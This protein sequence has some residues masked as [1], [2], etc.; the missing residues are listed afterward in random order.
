MGPA[1]LVD[2]STFQSLS[3][4]EVFYLRQYYHVVYCST[5]F[6]ETLADLA[7]CSDIE[8]GKKEVSKISYKI[9]GMDTCFTTEFRE[10]LTAELF[11]YEI[12]MNGKPILSGGRDVVVD[13]GNR[14]VFF[15]E[16]PEY[17]ALRKWT[18]GEYSE[19]EKQLAENWRNST[20]NITLDKAK[21]QS[22]SFKKIKN[23][24]ELKKFTTEI[25][26]N[27]EFQL[28]L[29][30]L[31]LSGI[32]FRQDIRDK[33]CKRWLD[34]GMPL[35][36]NYAPY[37]YYYLLVNLTFHLGVSRNLVSDRLTNII[38]LEYVYY[39]P[40]CKVFTSSD[41]FLRNFSQLFLTEGQTFTWGEDLKSDLKAFCDYWGEKGDDERF[42]YQQDYENYPPDIPGSL[43]CSIWQKWARTGRRKQEKLTLERKKEIM[44]KLKPI[45]E[46]IKKIEKE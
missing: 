22:D 12:E 11:G 19:A 36:K 44:K 26:E 20:K 30:Q 28:D 18:G 42:R 7:K 37:T 32:T 16:P 1:I 9:N 21:N 27:P 35:I 39:L 31:V 4:G 14:G 2:K 40:F 8:A 43:T 29:L 46:Q 25:L 15:D 34:F 13:E 17:E 6:Y 45:M 23:V 5:L 41:K 10:L 3:K 38:D 24:D 33:V